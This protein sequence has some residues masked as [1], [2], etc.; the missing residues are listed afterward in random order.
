MQTLNAFLLGVIA[1][2][3]GILVFGAPPR[4]TQA[5][6]VDAGGGYVVGTVPLDPAGRNFVWV[7]NAADKG[8]PRLAMYE[9]KETGLILKF[10]RNLTYDFLYDQFPARADSHI[11]SVEDVF[12]ETKKKRDEERKGGGAGEKPK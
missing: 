4:P 2:F 12:R 10:S 11:P 6:T 7:L 8:S 1:T 3:L 5:Q 9:A